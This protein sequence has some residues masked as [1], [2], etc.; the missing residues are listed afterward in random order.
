M[1]S[2]S[3]ARRVPAMSYIDNTDNCAAQTANMKYLTSERSRITIWQRAKSATTIEGLDE[4]QFCGNDRSRL[5][6]Q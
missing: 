5:L 3:L 2:V 1:G 6:N 4:Y